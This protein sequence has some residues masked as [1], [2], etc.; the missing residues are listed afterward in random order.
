ME[1]IEV[2][3]KSLD[4]AVELALDR[5]GVVD[6]ELEYE[7][8]RRA[9]QSGCSALGR[10]K[11][12]IRARVKPLSREKPIDRRR[13]R[14]GERAALRRSAGRCASRRP[15]RRASAAEVGGGA[16]PSAARRQ[17]RTASR[18][19]S[20]RRPRGR[21]AA[22]A[23]ARHVE[24]ERDDG[25]GQRGGG[26]RRG[27]RSSA[28]DR[29][30]GECRH[31][32]FTD[33]LVRDFGLDAQ[34]SAPRSSTTTS[35]CGS[36]GSRASASW[37]GPKGATLHALEELV[38]AVVQHAAGGH[39]ARLHLDVAG[40]RERRREALAAFA[41]AGR[42]RGPRVGHRAGARADDPARPQGRARHRRRARRCR[43]DL[44][45][46]GASAPGRDQARREPTARRERHR[47]TRPRRRCSNGLAITAPSGPGPVATHLDA[48]PGLRRGRGSSAGSAP[49]RRSSTSAA[50]AGCPGLGARVRLARAPVIARR[51]RPSA[52]HGRSRS[53]GRRGA[54]RRT[55]GSGCVTARAEVVAHEPG[56]PG[57]GA[58]W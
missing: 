48:R 1:W 32:R 15:P 9:P 27:R 47:P 16:T 22:A 7:V 3:A 46:R 18:E 10:V 43:D 54:R 45:G 21:G 30:A 53:G 49:D 37:S 24:A 55:T 6:D 42:R 26:E 29:R 50:A 8:A 19:R 58:I 5:L 52:G 14:R 2:S 28:D 4:E 44:G 34:P 25:S 11:A 35:N 31:V 56:V 40:Y 39:S 38:R 57:S 36:T 51:R 17:P 33:E 41:D 13:R 20:R 12:R 23:A